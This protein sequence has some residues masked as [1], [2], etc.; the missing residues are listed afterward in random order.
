MAR[1][2][3][4]DAVSAAVALGAHLYSSLI[5]TKRAA[6][7]HRVR[8]TRFVSVL[9]LSAGVACAA[10]ESAQVESGSAG[11]SSVAT[12]TMESSPDPSSPPSQTQNEAMINRPIWVEGGAFVMGTDGGRDSW[13]PAHEVMVSGFWIQEHEVTNAEFLRFDSAHFSTGSPDDPAVYVQWAQA[14]AYA[15]SIGGTLPTE[16]QWELAARGLEGRVY[17]WGAAVPSCEL[18]HYDACEPRETLP[19]MSLAAGA[20]PEGIHDLA[21]NVA[22]WVFD[23]YGPYTAARAID[24]TGPAVGVEDMDRRVLRGGGWALGSEYL[25]GFARVGWPE[26]AEGE[27]VSEMW[28]VG[29]RVAWPGD[30]EPAS[31]PRPR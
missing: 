26:I 29:F 18:A 20:T 30:A 4:L 22:E 23:R 10:P 14:L 31:P 8:S 13:G 28:F 6:M 9:F 5:R 19:V 3:D 24:P 17:P 12:P 25:A 21:G 27:E 7:N 15:E 16:A 11:D 2:Q 1:R